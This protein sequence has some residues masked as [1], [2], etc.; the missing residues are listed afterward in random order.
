[1]DSERL[2]AVQTARDWLNTNGLPPVF[3]DTETTGLGNH[4]EVCSVAVVD[5]AGQVLLESLVKP[6]KPIPADA[7]NIHGITDEMVKDAPALESLFDQLRAALEGKTVIAYNAPFDWGMLR[8]SVQRPE[9]KTWFDAPRNV[10][11]AMELYAVFY[12]DWSDYFESYKWQKLSSA[13]GQCGLEVRWDQLHSAAVDADLT[14]RIMKYMAD[15]KPEA[16]ED[17]QPDRTIAE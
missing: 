7:T 16:E 6:S 14:R 8:N 12:G 1:M 11:C 9:C 2:Q 13:A 5:L 10:R 15:Y 17:E 4:D 3:L